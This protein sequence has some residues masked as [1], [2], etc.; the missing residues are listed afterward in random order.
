MGKQ[1][2]AE[3]GILRI[4]ATLAVLL[5]H[6]CNTLSNNRELFSLSQEQYQFFS[7]IKSLMNWAVPV[8]FMI[9]GS[10]LLDKEKIITYEQVFKK[11]IKRMVVVLFV[12]GVPFS[13]IEQ[14]AN[15]KAFA[16]Y[17][18]LESI[19]NVV[20]G[21]SWGHLWYLYG[22]IG[23]YLVMPVIKAFV[24]IA[25]KEAVQYLLGILFIFDFII[26][27]INRI[28]NIKIGFEMPL[29][30]YYVFYVILGYYLFYLAR[31]KKARL[32]ISLFVGVFTAG[33]IVLCRILSDDVYGLTGY[34][35]PLIVILSISIFA[36]VCQCKLVKFNDLIKTIDK[37]CFGVYLI[38]PLF[39]N[40][41]YKFL[42]FSPISFNW[43]KIAVIPFWV[44][45]IVLAFATSWFLSKIPI[46]RDYLR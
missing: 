27:I 43:Y 46:L 28:L 13:L 22:L 26:P 2:K 20:T 15:A 33:M 14:I 34:A 35:S 31:T 42:H 3:L 37:Y 7:I 41:F 39:T 19:A 9:T 36:M 21:N 24:N 5:L 30:A 45:L 44:G 17:M 11:Y 25:N 8:F 23:W 40:G 6:T 32:M 38:H 16:F 4:A 1:Y 10:L 29:T 18:I 12:F